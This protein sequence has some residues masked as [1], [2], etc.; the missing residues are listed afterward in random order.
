MGLVDEKQFAL[1]CTPIINLFPKRTDRL[2]IN[3]KDSEFILNTDR[4]RPTDFEVYS[5]S[6]LYAQEYQE[7]ES[8]EFRPLYQSLH[9]DEGNHGRYFSLRREP[10]L[11]SDSTRKYGTRTPYIGSEVFVSLVDQNE[12]PFSQNLHY[13]TV[14]AML[15]NR[16]LPRLVPRNGVSDLSTSDSIPA[17]SI[18]LARPTSVPRP[19][20]AQREHAWRLIRQLNFNYIPLTELTERE[21]AQALRDM[22]RL[23]VQSDDTII[24]K[25]IDS[26]IG[27]KLLTAMRRLPGKGPLV[28]GRGIECQLTVDEDGFSGSS[29]YLFGLILENYI[30]RH[31][32]INTFTQVSLHSMQRGEITRWPVRMGTR[33]TI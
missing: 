14:Q 13:L 18:G 32:A 4:S 10:R 7:S 31:V 8:L 12:A 11:A 26:L 15:T 28:Y 24:Q 27:S 6:K 21:G 16:D 17:K 2:E 29:P 3:Y 33:G 9:Q 25:Q 1:Y 5:V 20:F 22:L 23:F 30:A 19:S